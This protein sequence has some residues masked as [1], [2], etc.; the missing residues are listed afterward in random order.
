MLKW[1]STLTGI[2]NTDFRKSFPKLLSLPIRVICNTGRGEEYTIKKSRKKSVNF[3]ARGALLAR[4]LSQQISRTKLDYT[5]CIFDKRNF[6]L[7]IRCNRNTKKNDKTFQSDRF[8]K[9]S[10]KE[11]CKRIKKKDFYSYTSSIGRYQIKSIY[12]YREITLLLK[13]LRQIFNL[14]LIISIFFYA[15]T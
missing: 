12:F 6:I 15:S 7:L 14:I 2:A 10:W 3:R 4:L 5:K 8:S 9:K 13:L 1:Q 11:R